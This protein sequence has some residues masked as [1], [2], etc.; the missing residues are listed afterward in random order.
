MFIS[1]P[2]AQSRF[3]L[4]EISLWFGLGD[5]L[6]RDHGPGSTQ[7]NMKKKWVGEKSEP[8][9]TSCSV[10]FLLLFVSLLLYEHTD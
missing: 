7:E 5:N 1:M 8:V 6:L 2:K 4:C 9:Y 10:I 3:T